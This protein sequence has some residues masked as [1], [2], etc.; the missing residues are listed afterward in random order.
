MYSIVG[1]CPQCGAPIY[2]PSI[3]SGVIPP[4]PQY[5]CNCPPRTRY[6]VLPTTVPFA[7]VI[8]WE[9]APEPAPQ[10]FVP[11]QPFV[12]TRPQ[13]PM[14]LQQGWVCP[15]CKTVNSPS[16]ERCGCKPVNKPGEPA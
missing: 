6:I 15:R 16:V 7:P 12:P 13:V 11:M 5:S 4:T 2:V 1:S 10:P 8:P 9:P 3:W 14:P